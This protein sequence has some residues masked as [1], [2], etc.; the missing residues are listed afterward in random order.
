MVIWLIGMSRA[1]KTVIGREV[2]NLLK[3]KQP[4][5]VFLDG[6]IVREI[7]GNDLGHTIEDRRKNAWRIC[8]LCKFLD[9]QGIDVVCSIL[10]I[11][12]ETQE[13]NRMNIP[14]Y[15]QVYLRVPMEQ[16]IE[17]DSRGLYLRART[18]E[19]KNVVG[20]DIEFPQPVGTDLTIDNDK[21]A[22]SFVEIA[23]EIVSSIPWEINNHER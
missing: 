10:S 23:S 7:M 12:P 3:A 21:P 18:G 15:F 5:V 4:N 9:S 11:F 1:G 17:R 2:Y 13:W 22:G 14:R 19:I 8:R 16:L 20:I 6:D